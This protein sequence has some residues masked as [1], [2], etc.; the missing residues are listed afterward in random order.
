M[1]AACYL[2]RVRGRYV[3]RRRIPARIRSR[4]YRSEVVKDLAPCTFT[5]AKRRALCLAVASDELFAAVAKEALTP[6][7]VDAIARDLFDRALRLD[8]ARLVEFQPAGEAERSDEVERVRRQHEN[9]RQA[10]CGN[11]WWIAAEA[12]GRELAGL[13][14]EAAAGDPVYRDLCRKLLRV[15]VEAMRL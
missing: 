3:F 4:C 10:L 2:R 14:L 9:C 15:G 12:T 6:K 1:A 7:R 13:G 8:D 11:V 5:E